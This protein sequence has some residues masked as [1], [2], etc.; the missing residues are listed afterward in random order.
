MNVSEVN[1]NIL[2]QKTNSKENNVITNTLKDTKNL[3]TFL[4]I[5]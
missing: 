3:T 1:W 5:Y 2:T 4:F